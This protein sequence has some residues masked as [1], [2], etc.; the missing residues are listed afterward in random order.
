MSV[1][2]KVVIIAGAS[3]GIGAATAKLLAQQGAKLM[4][5]ARHQEPLN[6]IRNQFPAAEILTKAVDV[7]DR[8]QVQAAVNETK[9][10]FGRIDVMFNNAGIMPISNLADLKYDDW[11]NTI[12][13]NVMG[14]LNGI[15]AV[16]PIMRAQGRGHILSTSSVAGHK[17]FPGFAVYSGS[18]FAV[19]AIMEGLRQEEAA[20]HI[21]STII[22]PGSATTNLYTPTT[23]DE[24]AAR[25]NANVSLRPEDV[26]QQVVRVIDTPA[27]VTVSEVQIRPIE[28]QY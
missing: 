25:E 21:K 13:I 10:R 17:V 8:D 2:D 9:E 14:V 19:R 28:Q 23:A 22:T 18:K 11:A 7:T 27:N 15:Y 16:L 12:N 4:L 24:R 1:K 5:L 26:A 6:E 20:N 3:S